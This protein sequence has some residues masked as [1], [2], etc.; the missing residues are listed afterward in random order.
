MNRDRD[1]SMDRLIADALKARA[2]TEPATACVDAETLAAWADGALDPREREAVDTHAADC[3]RCQQL[4]AAMARTLPVAPEARPWWRLST[5]GWLVPLTAAATALAIWIAVPRPE[6]LVVSD[7]GAGVAD[8]LPAAPS[9][10]LTVPGRE[11]A[12]SES[13]AAP[14]TSRAT[15]QAKVDR[16][17]RRDRRAATVA[18]APTE[19]IE[20]PREQRESGSVQKQTVPSAAA[21]DTKVA[22]AANEST[23]ATPQAAP[24]ASRAFAPPPGAAA[25]APAPSV[26]P[27][28]PAQSAD[29]AVTLRRDNALASARTARLAGVSETIFASSNPSTR[30]KLLRGGGVQRSADGGATWRTEVTG[31]AD[32]LAAGASP[33]PSVCWLVGPSGTVLLSTDGRTWRRLGFPERVDLRMVTATDHDNATV[34]TADGRVFVTADGGQTW[35][36]TPGI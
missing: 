2:G 27:P 4:L 36:R 12:K 29:A 17:D 23:A 3:A 6:P 21:A 15:N 11:A 26:A 33:S 31:A 24:S 9:S 22:G 18:P 5:F 20:A 16:R 30:F 8:R 25:G 7:G 35:A 19:L 1:A 10:A 32:T 14:E 13:S 34:T 28:S